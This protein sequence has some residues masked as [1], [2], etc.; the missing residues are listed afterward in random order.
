MDWSPA[1]SMPS[2]RHRG[3]PPHH[4][5]GR[6]LWSGAKR[7]ARAPPGSKCSREGC[8]EVAH[9]QC[10]AEGF[11]VPRESECDYPVSRTL[12][13]AKD[14][15][16][17]LDAYTVAVVEIAGGVMS[18]RLGPT[19]FAIILHCSG[20]NRDHVAG[21]DRVGSEPGRMCCWEGGPEQPPG[22]RSP[23]RRHNRLISAGSTVVARPVTQDD[24]P[25]FCTVK[26]GTARGFCE[27]LATSLRSGPPDG[28]SGA[29]T[30][31][32]ARTKRR[33]EGLSIG[34]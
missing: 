22:A 18:R 29:F 28:A 9:D 13:Y 26:A 25:P 24:A 5:Q 10:R 6:Q 15:T 1:P 11:R 19:A 27:N 2:P 12:N 32:T 17:D 30:G 23:S 14:L 33:N 7:P 21:G 3:W 31:N 16:V 4:H 8:C 20:I 34:P